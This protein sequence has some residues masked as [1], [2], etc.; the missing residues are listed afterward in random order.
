M[1][2]IV[3]VNVHRALHAWMVP[4]QFGIDAS[5]TLETVRNPLVTPTLMSA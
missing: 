4:F 2:V 3:V 1:L 5:N